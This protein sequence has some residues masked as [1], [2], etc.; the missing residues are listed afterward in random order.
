[1]EYAIKSTPANYTRS[2]ENLEILGGG[3]R[4]VAAVVNGQKKEKINP[5]SQYLSAGQHFDKLKQ[6]LPAV[7]ICDKYI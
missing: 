2:K 5:I 7:L 4:T 6:I 1:M 3:R